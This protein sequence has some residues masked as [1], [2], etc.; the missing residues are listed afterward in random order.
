MNTPLYMFHTLLDNMQTVNFNYYLPDRVQREWLIVRET[1]TNM[2]KI[3]GFKV[4]EVHI[5]IHSKVLYC[6]LFITESLEYS[7]SL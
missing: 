5:Y 2:A 6:N 4:L 7:L 1:M 3:I